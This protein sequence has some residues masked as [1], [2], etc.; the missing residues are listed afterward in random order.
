MTPNHN[1]VVRTEFTRQ[2]E[3]YAATPVVTDAQRLERLVTAITPPPE[4]RVIEVATGPGYVAM[5]LA[6]HC[7]EVIGLDLTPAPL[8]IAERN[9]HERGLRNVSFQLGDAQALPFGAGTFD[10]AVCRFA[11]HH[12]EEPAAVV[13]EMARVCRGGGIIAVEDL[14][15][16]E[17]AAR[18]EY[19]DRIEILRDSS[20]TRVLPLSELARTLGAV[21]VEV[22]RLYSDELT[23][24]VED[25]MQ[26]AQTT[27]DDA[28][29]VRRLL[30][31]DMRD[32]LSGVRPFMQDGRM[33]FV[34]RTVA[35][36]GRKFQ[37]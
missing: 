9:R 25:W 4:A 22:E 31:A 28:M 27:A 36:V 7:R 17:N 12:F 2:A 8:A 29:E 11:L 19:W 34:Q 16:S 26:R 3:A 30:E 10:V 1:D 13:A 35:I 37:S 15:A 32:N 20:H 6:E 23:P 21:G 14:Y 24:D 18:A 5:A 33:H